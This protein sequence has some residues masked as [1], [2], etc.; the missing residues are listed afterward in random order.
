MNRRHF[1]TTL[2]AATAAS[3]FLPRAADAFKWKQSPGGMWIINPAWKMATYEWQFWGPSGNMLI[4]P[5]SRRFELIGG[6]MSEVPVFLR[7]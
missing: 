1:I 2:S 6:A 7:K 5:W 4:D 3:I